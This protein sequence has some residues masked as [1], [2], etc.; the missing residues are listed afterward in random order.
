MIVQ[1]TIYGLTGVPYEGQ[2]RCNA[3]D[4]S[5]MVFREVGTSNQMTTDSITI[6]NGLVNIEVVGDPAAFLIVAEDA[7]TQVAVVGGVWYYA[8]ALDEYSHNISYG[9]DYTGYMCA[10]IIPNSG[11]FSL[12][13]HLQAG[14][15]SDGVLGYLPPTLVPSVGAAFCATVG[16]VFALGTIAAV[17][18]EIKLDV[19]P[20]AGDKIQIL[21]SVWTINS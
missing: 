1:G 19:A 17:T 3:I 7:P 14:A 2:L 5:D 15:L 10:V 12:A 6:A 16:G 11:C 18:G 20:N 4:G 13:G 8:N 9:T 21:G